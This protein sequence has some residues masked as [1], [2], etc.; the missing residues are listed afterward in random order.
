MHILNICIP[1]VVSTGQSQIIS[2]NVTHGSFFFT[3]LLLSLEPHR[4]FVHC[5]TIW[6]FILSAFI[7][8][9]FLQYRLLV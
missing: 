3:F 8:F 7:K 5:F 1:F 2:L 4:E 6:M 9:F